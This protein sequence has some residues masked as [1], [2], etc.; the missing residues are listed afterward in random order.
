MG[1]GSILFGMLSRLSIVRFFKLPSDQRKFSE[2]YFLI[3]GFFFAGDLT[4]WHISFQYTTIANAAILANLASIFVPIYGYYIWRER[5]E[6]SFF[7][8]VLIAFIGVAGLCYFGYGKLHS[9]QT[10]GDHFLGDSLAVIT[11]VFYSG[12]IITTKRYVGKFSTPVIMMMSSGWA[13]LFL[14]IAAYFYGGNIFPRSLSCW[15]Y[16][17]GLAT[18]SQVCGQGLITFAMKKIDASI[19]AVVAL[20]APTSS[21]IFGVIVLGQSL[22][23]FQILSIQVVIVGLAVTSRSKKLIKR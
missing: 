20:L 10:A 18:V 6:K 12:Y 23:V 7:L 14:L 1:I 15:G 21:A 9:H 8:G 3:P 13:A 16:V 11:G 22:S 17:I 4:L 5:R 2:F 19:T